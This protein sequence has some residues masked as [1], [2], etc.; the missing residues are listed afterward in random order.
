MDIYK[1]WIY[2]KISTFYIEIS[3]TVIHHRSGQNVQQNL[4]FIWLIVY[5]SKNFR[6]T[7]LINYMQVYF[8][9]YVFFV[10]YSTVAPSEYNTDFYLRWNVIRSFYSN[11]ENQMKILFLLDIFIVLFANKISYKA[12]KLLYFITIFY[13]FLR[14]I[15]MF[16]L[17]N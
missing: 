6:K 2:T 3:C 16:M 12:C 14:I 1:I 11:I 17:N 13:I 10:F 8:I 7:F 15:S 9:Y 4:N 5:T